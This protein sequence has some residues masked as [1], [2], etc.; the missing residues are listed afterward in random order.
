MGHDPQFRGSKVYADRS[1]LSYVL[2]RELR[3][4]PRG[5]NP[6]VVNERIAQYHSDMHSVNTHEVA[7][8]QD[9]KKIENRYKAVGGDAAEIRR[10]YTAWWNYQEAVDEKKS[11]TGQRKLTGRQTAEILDEVIRENYPE[12]TSSLWDTSV[13]TDAWQAKYK[14]PLDDYISQLKDLINAGRHQLFSDYSNY[15]P[16]ASTG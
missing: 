10:S 12:Y 3:F 14:K 8:N 16:N 1:W 4:F 9:W 13:M 6:E 2:Q 7:R 15:G 11:S 5:V